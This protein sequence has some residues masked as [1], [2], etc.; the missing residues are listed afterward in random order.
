MSAISEKLG[1]RLSFFRK[2]RALEP[3]LDEEYEEYQ[4]KCRLNPFPMGLF[5]PFGVLLIP[6]DGVHATWS[7][8][9]KAQATYL[10]LCGHIAWQYRD[11]H[12]FD[13]RNEAYLATFTAA[14]MP[15]NDLEEVVEEM[16]KQ[17][18]ERS[19]H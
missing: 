3:K 14:M 12:F 5:A 6:F 11:K 18:S 1:L 4:Q 15:E 19:N 10:R 2:I 7:T 9:L 8:C 17:Q 16:T 13:F